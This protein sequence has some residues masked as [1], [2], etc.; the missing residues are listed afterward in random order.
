ME[1]KLA[2]VKTGVTINGIEHI[3]DL[4]VMDYRNKSISSETVTSFDVNKAIQTKLWTKA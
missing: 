3:E 2:W 4:P 1:R